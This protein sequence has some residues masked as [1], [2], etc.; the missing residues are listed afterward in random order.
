MSNGTEN[1]KSKAGRPCDAFGPSVI[2]RPLLRVRFVD[3]TGV[4]QQS[5]LYS[6]WYSVER[7]V[8]SG[9]DDGCDDGCGEKTPCV[10]LDAIRS[11]VKRNNC[12][13]LGVEL[14]Q[15][16]MVAQLC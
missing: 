14:V 8:V 15:T 4:E 12:T 7:S 10:F 9:C 1:V 5:T 13:L 6:S 16:Q 3:P 2:E 11:I